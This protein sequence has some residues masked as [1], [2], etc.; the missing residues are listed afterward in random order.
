MAATYDGDEQYAVMLLH[1]RMAFWKLTEAIVREQELL[2]NEPIGHWV[3]NHTFKWLDT[4]FHEYHEWCLHAEVANLRQSQT[5]DS[6][7]Q[8][9]AQY[10]S[11]VQHSRDPS[12]L[13]SPPTAPV[14]V[15]F[16]NPT[17]AVARS[18]Q[19]STS[20]RP[21]Q[22]VSDFHPEQNRFND[23]DRHPDSFKNSDSGRISESGR[24]FFRVSSGISDLERSS[25]QG[26]TSEQEHLQQTQI[27]NLTAPIPSLR[28]INPSDMAQF[29]DDLTRIISHNSSVQISQTISESIA[30]QIGYRFVSS[31]LISRDETAQA[32]IIGLTL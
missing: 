19:S 28:S 23:P 5:S 2:P 14:G 12:P 7:S 1:K 25:V 18:G 17:D 10:G 24:N 26:R 15:L 8:R 16:P 29:V 3:S 31:D 27:Y 4:I 22:S 13:R 20:S 6:H 21:F 32:P 30:R 11:A 9:S